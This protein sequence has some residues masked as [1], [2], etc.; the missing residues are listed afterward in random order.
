MWKTSCIACVAGVV[1]IA[2]SSGSSGGGG[3]TAICAKGTFQLSGTLD[4]ANANGAYGAA[5]QFMFE[6]ALGSSPGDVKVAFG[7]GGQLDLTWAMLV[8]DGQ[9]TPVTG[10]LV[11]PSEGPHPG[12]MYCITA[13]TMTPNPPGEDGVSFT[14]TG[15]ASGACPGTPVSA[16]LSGCAASN[17]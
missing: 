15:L 4:G 13:G 9:T 10:T 3:G 2:C 11:M 14:I 7:T 5:T 12:T 8:A 17:L 16:S 1:S 6:N